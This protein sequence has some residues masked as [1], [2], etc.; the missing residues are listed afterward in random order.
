MTHTPGYIPPAQR[1]PGNGVRLGPAA[2]KK[3]V[4]L[5]VKY[6]FVPCKLEARGYLHG[7]SVRLCRKLRDLDLTKEAVEA[8]PP[9]RLHELVYPKSKPRSDSLDEQGNPVHISPDLE[10]ISKALKE[11]PYLT[12]S[13]AFKELYYE[14]PQNLRLAEHGRKFLKESTL[15][16]RLRQYAKEHG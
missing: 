12:R 16:A 14:D 6:D 1:K 15:Y 5:A 7:T 2:L 9:K 11:R 10:A 13:E 3:F 4:L 8:M